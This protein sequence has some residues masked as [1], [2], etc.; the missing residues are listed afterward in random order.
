M[1]ATVVTAMTIAM[2]PVF[3]LGRDAGAITLDGGDFLYVD[4]P[5]DNCA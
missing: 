2:I 5:V 4:N 3:I 1:V